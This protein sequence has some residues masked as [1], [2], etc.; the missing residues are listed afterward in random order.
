[1]KKIIMIL[2]LC[3]S[4]LF[5]GCCPFYNLSNYVMPDDV[6]FLTVIEEKNTPVKFCIYMQENYEWEFHLLNYSPYQMWLANVKTRTGDCNDMSCAIMFAMNYN[7]Y[8]TYQI[9]VCFKNS[10]VGHALAVFV[11]NNK[12][13]YSSNMYY[14]PIY[15]NT[16][17]EIVDDYFTYQTKEFKS[18]KVYDYNNNLIERG[19]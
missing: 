8:E 19:E 9:F 14:H 4:L 10:I 16:F 18:Y 3:I 17:K 2:V 13:T 6:E 12:Y 7:G 15:V 1:M 11:E 5:T